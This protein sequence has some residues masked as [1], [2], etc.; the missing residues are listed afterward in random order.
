MK[1]G[2][3]PRIPARLG[4]SAHRRAVELSA[5]ALAL[6]LMPATL[7][8]AEAPVVDSLI[9]S[10][11]T[12]APGESVT[13]TVAA[14]DPDCPDVC[15]SGCGQYVRADL[16][17]WE[18]DGG[19]F[20]AEDD[21]V[22]ASPYS[23]TAEWQAPV[24]EATYTLTVFL[25]DSGSFFCGGRQSTSADVTVLV[26]TTTNEPPAIDSLAANPTQLFP[27]GTSALECAATDPDGDPV[28]YSWAAD[29]GTVTPGAGGSAVFTAGDPALAGVTCTATD[30][31]GAF[32]E[33]TVVVSVTGAV[34]DSSLDSALASPQR[35]AVDAMG[36]VYVADRRGG[37]IAVLHLGSGELIYRL[38]VPGVSS[39]DVDWDGRLLVGTGAGA[40][41][42]DRA[43]EPVL[44][45]GS[46]QVSD[47][48]ADPVSRRWGVLYGR[49]GRA[50]IYDETGAV[51]AELGTAGELKSPR[52]LAAT[53]AGE[54][55]VGDTGNGLIRVFT[56][57]GS[58]VR[59]FG[60]GSGGGV[61]EFVQ[62][63]DVAVDGAGLIYASDSFQDWV[64]VWSSGGTLREVLG[65]YGEGRGQFQTAAGIAPAG[66]FGRLLAASLNGS[67]IEVFRTGDDPP[68]VP[69]PAAL[70][71]ATHLTFSPQAVATTSAPRA[72]ALTNG[73]DAPLGVR[74]AG[75]EGDF[76]QT[77]DCGLFLDPGAAC[78]FSVTATPPAAGPFAG[79]LRI[80][81]STGPLV[82][83]LAGSGF[84]PPGVLLVPGRLDYSDQ[85][86]ETASEP[87]AVVLQNSGT[88]PLVIGSITASSQYSQ[89]N[90]CGPTLAGGGSCV[91]QVVFA[92]EQ[93]ADHILG[94]LTVASNAA[95]SP[96]M[97]ALDGRGIERPE[98]A[99]PPAVVGVASGGSELEACRA[100]SQA[101]HQISVQFSEPMSYRPE[102]PEPGDANH[103]GSYLLLA[104]GPDQRF[105]TV[106]CGAALGDDLAVSLG[107]VAYDPES[108]VATLELAGAGAL[109][110]SL[111]RLFVCGSTPALSDLAGE[112]LDGDGDGSGGDDFTLTF[113]A[114]H[115]NLFQNGHFDCDLEG[116]TRVSTFDG[117][118]ERS[119]EDAGGSDLSGSV[120]FVPLTPEAIGIGQ[121]LP[122]EPSRAYRFEASFRWSNP[123]PDQVGFLVASCEV[124]AEAECSGLA[125]GEGVLVLPLVDPPAAW[126][127]LDDTL[128]TPGGSR[129]A[130]CSFSLSAEPDLEANLDRLVLSEDA[131][132]F[133]DGFESG[134]AGTWSSAT[135]VAPSARE[136]N[137]RER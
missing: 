98:H 37:G 56:A 111:H 15:V 90:D 18:A 60:G 128:E 110:A 96:H 53:P 120:H 112:P 74:A 57:S 123:V 86:L 9:A 89:A 124:F 106:G 64:Q 63:D 38:P 29:S 134:D 72:V 88:Q 121:C 125:V 41:V 99:G 102:D 42:L 49:L 100:S 113:R 66:V 47:V 105:D 16:T 132:V 116:W 108:W 50:L 25:S 137:A 3:V 68:P 27:G 80:D 30:P 107:G 12:V 95:G 13:L 10:P 46:G 33:E 24:A 48:A 119:P 81:T 8:A 122:V 75:V 73:G 92:P 22:S 52:G 20:T 1:C 101:I 17:R 14:H 19:T 11:A 131:L 136:G 45:L 5:F 126:A 104:A 117:E 84:V 55:V 67:R 44:A 28:A 21:G 118:I 135:G 26:T 77:N 85:E 129:S 36:E 93:I 58:L 70:L 83:E 32:T 76:A 115:P 31:A 61:G 69:E 94:T 2:T 133:A 7:G 78:A 79:V 114:D 4:N 103:P 51:Q 65:T 59:S 54:W 23:A 127:T 71:S 82:V 43:G 6:A 109:P 62:L 34:A 87:K 91:I 35:L 39:V 40:M 130:L 97:V